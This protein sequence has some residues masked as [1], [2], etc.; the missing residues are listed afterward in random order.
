MPGLIPGAGPDWESALLVLVP[1]AEPAVGQHR[2]RLDGAARDGVPAHITV[3]YPSPSASGKPPGI[4][5]RHIA[6]HAKPPAPAEPAPHRAGS[7]PGE[8]MN[9]GRRPRR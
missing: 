5:D 9:H 3:L 8:T 4:A 7:L 2:A 1:A 6:E